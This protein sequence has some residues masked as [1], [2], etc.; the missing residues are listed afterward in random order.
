MNIVHI[1][2]ASYFLSPPLL[3]LGDTILGLGL[4]TM[5]MVH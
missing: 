3:S 1:F 5:V 4:E 2:S